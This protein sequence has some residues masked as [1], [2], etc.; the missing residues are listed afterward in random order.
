VNI[1]KAVQHAARLTAEAAKVPAP[2]GA[3]AGS[4]E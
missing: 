2:E 4:A 3:M 1:V